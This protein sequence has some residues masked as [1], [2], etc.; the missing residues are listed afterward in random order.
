M[1]NTPEEQMELA[2]LFLQF[3]QSR[4]QLSKSTKNMGACFRSYNFTA[5]PEELSGYTKYAQDVY[6]YIQE[7]AKYFI[8]NRKAQIWENEPNA[9]LR[10]NCMPETNYYDVFSFVNNMPNLSVNEIY[11][12]IVNNAIAS[13]GGI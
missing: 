3:A 10:W 6:K 2:K 7:G 4:E 12:R 5:T 8:G 11:N 9:F 1:D 13:S